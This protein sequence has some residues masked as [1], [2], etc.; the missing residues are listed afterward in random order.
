MGQK[1]KVRKSIW[2]KQKEVVLRSFETVAKNK[3]TVFIG[4]RVFKKVRKS[5]W[6][7]II[8][9]STG[10]NG[11]LSLVSVFDLCRQFSQM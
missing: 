3:N 4:I 6:A 9:V 8:R 1:Y 7:H 11:S 2:Q 5:I 10:K